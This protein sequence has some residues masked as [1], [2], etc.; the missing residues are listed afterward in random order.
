M[1]SSSLVDC[2]ITS[3]ETH[4]SC[5]ILNYY[6]RKDGVDRFDRNLEE[7]VCRCKSLPF[8]IAFAIRWMQ[9]STMLL[10]SSRK[11]NSIRKKNFSKIEI[12]HFAK[13]AAEVFLAVSSQ[14]HSVIDAAA[15][16]GMSVVRNALTSVRFRLRMTSNK[17]VRC[18]V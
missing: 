14:K 11:M 9:L 16:L 1:L 8:F 13:P 3:E 6:Q 4:K 17:Q 10:S 12:L 2:S 5:M 18:S 15:Q 7:F